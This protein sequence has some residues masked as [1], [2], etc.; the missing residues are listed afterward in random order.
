MA[1]SGSEWFLVFLNG[2]QWLSMF[3]SV[4]QWFPVGG[5]HAV[6]LCCSQFYKVLSLV[7]SCSLLLPCSG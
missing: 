1:I 5:E 3:T 7:T 2:S 4:S 6:V